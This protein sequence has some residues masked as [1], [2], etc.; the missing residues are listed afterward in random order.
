MFHF[1]VDWEMACVLRPVSPSPGPSLSFLPL[2]VNPLQSTG[3]KAQILCNQPGRC[4]SNESM[5]IVESQ[6][7][8][9][10]CLPFSSI[11]HTTPLF[12]DFLHNFDRVKQSYARPPL[13]HDWW[14]EELQ[15]IQYP[16]ERRDAVA[17]ILERQNR[18]FG[19]GEK[20]LANIQRLREGAPAVVTGQQVGLF[21][22]PT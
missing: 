21:G 1:I 13:D 7:L 5:Q 4:A 20:T 3:R 12:D 11:P 15:K 14:G 18:A 8:E 6:T 16:T 19:A 22:G 17:A 9:T 2:G 10:E